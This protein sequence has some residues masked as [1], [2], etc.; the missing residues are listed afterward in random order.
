MNTKKTLALILAVASAT[1][2]QAEIPNQKYLEYTAERCLRASDDDYA[3]KMHREISDALE[4]V[5]QKT[6]EELLAQPNISECLEKAQAIE[7]ARAKADS[8]RLLARLSR[9]VS[10]CAIS[11]DNHEILALF[12]DISAHLETYQFIEAEV[13]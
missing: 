4:Q 1:A 12:S 13:S 3:L 5:D 9:Q 11:G 7:T 10:Q 2:A 6:T 8:E